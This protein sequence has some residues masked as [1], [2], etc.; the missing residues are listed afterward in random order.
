MSQEIKLKMSPPW[1]TYINKLIALFDGD[2]Q[3]AFDV[4][5]DIPSVSIITNNGDKAAALVRLL[6]TKKQFGNVTLEINIKGKISNLAFRTNAKL[7]NTAFKDNPAF[8]QCV[9]PDDEYWYPCI[10]YVIFKNY[11]VQFFNDNL[12]DA[13]GIIS[14]LYQNI[15]A[16]LFEDALLSTGGVGYCTDIEHGNLGKPL[17]EWP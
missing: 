6:P 4:N 2:P 1:V 10:T 9:T 3:I 7:F 17:G 13:H 12:N 8:V 14:T 16:E 15:A 11:V 5:T